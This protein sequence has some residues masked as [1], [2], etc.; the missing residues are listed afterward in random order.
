[1]RLRP[2][3][4]ENI[5]KHP[6]LA[7]LEVLQDVADYAR[8]V[9]IASCPELN[10]IG[11]GEDGDCGDYARSVAALLEVFSELYDAIQAVD[12]AARHERKLIDDADIP[13]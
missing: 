13:F 2:H 5:E 12:D 8:A 4:P 3:R 7:A 6:D 1:M 9:V 11:Q 10:L